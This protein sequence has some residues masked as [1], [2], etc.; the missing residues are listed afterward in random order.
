MMVATTANYRSAD[1][2]KKLRQTQVAY[3]YLHN[4]AITRLCNRAM[5]LFFD[6]PREEE[7]IYIRL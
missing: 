5:D 2:E 7:H 4:T 1:G 6:I 3:R